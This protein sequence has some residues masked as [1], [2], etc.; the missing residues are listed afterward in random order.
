MCPKYG[1]AAALL[2][3]MSSL[4][5]VSLMWPN[6]ASICAISPMWQAKASAEPPSALM[7][8]ATVWQSSILRLDTITW[9]PCSASS[10]AIS[11][12]MPRLAP[13]TRAIFPFRSNNFVLILSLP[14]N[15]AAGGRDAGF[16]RQDTGD[17][18]VPAL[19]PVSCILYRCFKR[20]RGRS[21]WPFAPAVPPPGPRRRLF[22]WRRCRPGRAW[23]HP[24]RWPPGGKN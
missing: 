9:A 4:P 13:V 14:K 5:W 2:T 12:P 3:R 17:G 22:C 20:L 1:L 8:S 11:S 19:H 10:L 21:A 7:A 18:T 6:T 24:G 15:S 23:R 16:R